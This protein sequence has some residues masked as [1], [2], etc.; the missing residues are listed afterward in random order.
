M[1]K[2]KKAIEENLGKL[3]FKVYKLLKEYGKFGLD[4]S[5]VDAKEYA[6]RSVNFMLK[7]MIFEGEEIEKKLNNILGKV[8]ELEGQRLVVV[9]GVSVFGLCPHHLLP[10]EMRVSLGY[11]SDGK[12]LGLSKLARIAE[13]VAKKP[14]L[15]EEYV[16]E[17]VKVLDKVGVGSACL[18]E[19][20]HSCMRCRGVEQNESKVLSLEFSGVM[21]D[22]GNK[23]KEEFLFL[24]NKE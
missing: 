8:F 22:P 23:W 4:N 2:M 20:K 18:V 5:D 3:Y 10:V 6:R 1:K 11:V 24:V 7:E 14:L 9:L 13:L 21:V 15:Q 16:K 19:G 12:V 17:V